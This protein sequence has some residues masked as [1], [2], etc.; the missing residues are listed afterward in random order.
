MLPL[1][2]SIYR[3]LISFQ[4]VLL[5]LFSLYS[6]R[7]YHPRFVLPVFELDMSFSCSTKIFRLISYK[8][9]I[10]KNCRL[11]LHTPLFDYSFFCWRMSGFQFGGI[12]NKAAMNIL[13]Q[14]LLC[15][16]VLIS[17]S[18]ISRSRVNESQVRHIFTILRN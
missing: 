3:I 17:F 13:V 16:Y 10:F 9:F 14:I 2:K 11:V 18:C 5:S 7:D 8:Q 1:S 6:S 15:A 4:N 12:I